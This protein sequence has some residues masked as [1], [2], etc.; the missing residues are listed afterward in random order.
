MK[1]FALSLLLAVLCA[2]TDPDQT[3][4]DADGS[5]AGKRVTAFLQTYQSQHFRGLPDANLARALAPHLSPRLN[6]LLED[7]LRGQQKY[8]ARFPSDKP[9][10]VDGDIFSSLFEGATR[11]DVEAVTESADTATVRIK[12]I[13][14]DPATGKTIQTW[15]DRFLLIRSGQNWLI[16]DLE[17]QGS[18]DFA[19]RGKLSSALIETASLGQ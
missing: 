4:T 9:P 16:D 7:A 19:V 12:Y 18:W 1:V 17:Y 5:A 14:A 10:M 13:Y 6:G 3:M 11:G 2:C 8:K 15:N